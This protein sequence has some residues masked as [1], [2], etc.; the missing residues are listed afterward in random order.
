MATEFD[1]PETGFVL[2][3]QADFSASELVRLAESVV[4]SGFDSVWCNEEWGYSAFSILSRVAERVSCPLGTCV[5]SGFA[6]TP[7]ALA[8]NALALDEATDG[9]FLLGVGT[10]TPEIVEGFHG[11]PFDQPLLRLRET[12]EIVEQGLAGERMNYD[13]RQF[14]PEGFRLNHAPAAS[15]PILNAAVGPHNIAMSIEYAD[16]IMPHMI[17][18]PAID[19]AIARGEE[20]AGR[21]ADLHVLPTVPTCVTEDGD[22]ARQVLAKYVAYCLGST[23]VFADVIVEH[24]Y[25]DEI[26]VVQN[27]WDAGEHAAAADAVPPALLDEVGITGTPERARQ[28]L[29]ELT[30]EFESVLLTCPHGATREQVWT[31]V[32]ALP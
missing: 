15:V 6:R 14:K 11:V 4:E 20:R 25:A 10:G 8:A 16:G 27:H 31:T 7:A 24:G 23:R 12:F 2:P 32:N 19:D 17:P 5:V 18:F 1:Y 29:D 9:A 3:E 28:R 13:G 22:E 26:A 21:D 30:D